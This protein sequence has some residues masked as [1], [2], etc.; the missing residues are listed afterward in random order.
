MVVVMKDHPPVSPPPGMYPAPPK[1]SRLEKRQRTRVLE[2]LNRLA[3]E[4]YRNE[5]NRRL[6]LE[7]LNQIPEQN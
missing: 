5:I 1:L 3:R 4:D 2:D 7:R 6:L